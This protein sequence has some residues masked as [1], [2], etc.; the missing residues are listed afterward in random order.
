LERYATRHGIT[1]PLLSDSGSRVIR[2]FGIL[3]T[4]IPEDHDWF[5][6]PY[7]GTYMLDSEGRVFEKS[8]FAD[9]CERGSAN[10]FLQE[11][12]CVEDPKRGEVHRR[13]TPHL[14]ATAY[15]ASPSVRRSQRTMLTVEVALAAGVHVYGRPLPEGYIPI[16]LSV[17]GG[18]ALELLNVEYP[19][20]AEVTFE[21]I[22]ESLPAY[23]GTIRIKAKCAGTG[24]ETESA[25]VRVSL[26]YQACD[27]R[28]CYVPQTMDFDLPV[29]VLAHDWE[30]IELE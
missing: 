5:G 7:P 10:D 20:T 28:E 15:F 8:F 1:Y 11:S 2:A 9:H 17:D 25:R 22:G 6:L 14:T 23:E 16:E 19:P 30:R 4:H 18:E 27:S 12:F 3:N 29:E 21:A 13:E 26:R 24:R